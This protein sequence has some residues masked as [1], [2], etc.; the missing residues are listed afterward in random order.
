MVLIKCVGAWRALSELS[1]MEW[2]YADAWKIVELKRAMEP[3]VQFFAKEELELVRHITGQYPNPDGSFTI[4][5]AASAE[6][7][8]QRTELER[9]DTTLQL[10][11]PVKLPAPE[12]IRPELLEA[13]E[14]FVEF[15]EVSA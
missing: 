11:L 14:G 7:R 6:L 10:E 15:Q 2:N 13:L 1:S 12:R 5:A 3:Q 8:K 4:T 9:V